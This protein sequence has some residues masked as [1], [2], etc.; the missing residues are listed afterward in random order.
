M[1][2]QRFLYYFSNKNKMPVEIYTLGGYNE[3]G[4][5]CTAIKVDDEVIICD[6]GIHLESYI[7]YT[8]DEDILDISAL[9]LTE[10]GAIPDLASIKDLRNKVKA[11]IPT[12]AHL[13]HIGAI[14]FLAGKFHNAPVLGTPYTTAVIKA[15]LKDEKMKIPN[16]IKTLSPNSKY[17]V[18]KNIQ[19]E[20]INMTH[21]TPQ[22]VMVA[23]HTKYGTILYAND[24]KFDSNPTL[25]KKPNFKRLKEI[26]EKGIFALICDSTYAPLRA[27]TPSESVAKEMLKEVL[28]GTESTGKLVAV[29]TFSSHLAR[30]KSIV[31][32]G[33]L[34]NRKI[35]MMGRSL[36]K[37]IQAGQD[38]KII[39]FEKNAK[40]LRF[41]K[42]ISGKLKEIN[43]N[44]G[45]YLLVV[46]GHQGEPKAV[47]SRISKK[48]YDFEFKP[49]D[50]VVFSSSVIPTE[51]N[52]ENREKLENAL[53]NQG[54]R[55]FR[56]VHV[57]GH[58]AREDLRDLI[59]MVKPKFLIPAH[60]EPHMKEA[61]A[62]LAN[63]MGYKPENVF[64]SE[65]GNKIIL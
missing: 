3:V 8:Q 27:K 38:I 7:N 65:N 24:F 48:E 32:F 12:H 62:D 15:I 19:I 17:T 34:M 16:E 42:Q 58:A 23:I 25:G 9:R 47:L 55:I 2:I 37:Y 49:E 46:T 35:I 5:N 22:T 54:A 50:Q 4:K 29:T 61:L 51:I 63:E 64:L 57:S 6:L 45:K 26:G 40:I 21:S 18:S 39:N 60:G 1:L 33:K 43:K 36:S 11:V 56:D 41:R 14:P 59:N 10:V 13:D 52:R 44:R 20:F 53:K 28:L 30:L 31:E